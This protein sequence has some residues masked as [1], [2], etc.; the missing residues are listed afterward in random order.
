MLKPIKTSILNLIQVDAE[1]NAALKEHT[2]VVVTKK[3]TEERSDSPVYDIYACQG[4]LEGY[5]I[6]EY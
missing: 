6:I 2:L 5:K 4:R 3:G 1:V